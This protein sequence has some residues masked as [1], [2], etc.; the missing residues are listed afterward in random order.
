MTGIHIIDPVIDIIGHAIDNNR[1][2]LRRYGSHH[3]AYRRGHY[4]IISVTYIAVIYPIIII[5]P[6]PAHPNRKVPVGKIMQVQTKTRMVMIMIKETIIVM[7]PR[8]SNTNA[9]TPI[10][11]G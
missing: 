10:R 1:L 8:A 11:V 2:K 6:R 3:S 5:I 4:H 7:I 9:Y